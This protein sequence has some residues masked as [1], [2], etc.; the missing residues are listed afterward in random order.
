MNI[1][2]NLKQL[3]LNEQL[4]STLFIL[5]YFFF[6]WIN[7][8]LKMEH[9]RTNICSWLFQIGDVTNVDKSRIKLLFSYSSWSRKVLTYFVAFTSKR[10]RCHMFK[11]FWDGKQ[12]TVRGREEGIARGE[13]IVLVRTRENRRASKCFNTCIRWTRKNHQFCVFWGELWKNCQ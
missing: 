8:E 11:Y 2:F 4:S 10:E 13:H 1:H 3:E 5:S 12:C 6:Y 9:H 7:F